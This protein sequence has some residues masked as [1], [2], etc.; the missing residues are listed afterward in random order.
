MDLTSTGGDTLLQA[1]ALQV[2]FVA[3][4]VSA[5]QPH[6]IKLAKARSS[7][8]LASDAEVKSIIEQINKIE[9]TECRSELQ[10]LL[11]SERL[12]ENGYLSAI[13]SLKIIYNAKAH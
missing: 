5:D 9:K 7:C 11:I 13:E 1:L 6:R 3:I 10:R 2:P 4:P 8:F 12:V